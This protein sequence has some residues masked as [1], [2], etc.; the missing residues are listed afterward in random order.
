MAASGSAVF[1]ASYFVPMLEA[2]AHKGWTAAL[3]MTP[4]FQKSSENSKMISRSQKMVNFLE[5]ADPDTRHESVCFFQLK[6]CL[7]GSK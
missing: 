5:I 4:T 2:A 1:G 6:I 3:S 7:T